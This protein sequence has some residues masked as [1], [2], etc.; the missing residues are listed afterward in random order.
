[1]Y[2]IGNSAGCLPIRYTET[3]CVT[4]HF[5]YA[6]LIGDRAEQQ[7]RVGFYRIGDVELYIVA[8]GMGGHQLGAQASAAAVDAFIAAFGNSERKMS[9]RLLHALQAS[10]EKLTQTFL[11]TET[12]NYLPGT[13]LVALAISQNDA[14][15]VSVG[16]S[17]LYVF[18]GAQARRLNQDHSMRPVLEQQAKMGLIDCNDVESH[19][20]QGALRS[21]LVAGAQPILVDCPAEPYKF[22]KNDRFCLMS[23]GVLTLDLN[24]L[25]QIVSASDDAQ[26]AADEAISKIVHAEKHNQDNAS[27]I[28]VT[29]RLSLVD[30]I[31][32]YIGGS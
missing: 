16:D 22:H 7:D 32:H 21:A 8:D 31:K 24:A 12:D 9:E 23:D 25:R 5:G 28:V 19:P 30:R 2:E 10:Q 15:H 17:I 1:M 4:S 18:N 26:K 3:R 29:P 6:Q 11:P 27:L 14:W 13:T 20:Q